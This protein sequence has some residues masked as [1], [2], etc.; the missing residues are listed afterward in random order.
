MPCAN[1]LRIQV[2]FY[3]IN[4]QRSSMKN[5]AISRRLT[6][7]VSNV[8]T[9][10][11]VGS[12]VLWPTTSHWITRPSSNSVVRFQT[13][14]YLWFATWIK[15][16]LARVVMVTDLLCWIS[17]DTILAAVPFVLIESD[18]FICNKGT[19]TKKKCGCVWPTHNQMKIII[20]SPVWIQKVG[21]GRTN[22]LFSLL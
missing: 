11:N 21:F 7:L 8:N 15:G 9:T 18:I 10:Q 13:V 19:T 5:H 6:V 1:S 3:D 4:G 2:V 14:I 22:I 16:Y 20:F 17:S 12:G